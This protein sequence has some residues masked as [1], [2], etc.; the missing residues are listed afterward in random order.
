MSSVQLEH[1]V[2]FLNM[3]EMNKEWGGKREPPGVWE[4]ISQLWAK[5]REGDCEG[6]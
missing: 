4:P 6:D 1:Q 2:Q 5:G 3:F